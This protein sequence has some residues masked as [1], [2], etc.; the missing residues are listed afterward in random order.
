MESLLNFEDDTTVVATPSAKASS[1]CQDRE[2]PTDIAISD[3]MLCQASSST[4]RG[5]LMSW[6]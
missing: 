5:V 3:D 4:A 1:E 6:M 2:S